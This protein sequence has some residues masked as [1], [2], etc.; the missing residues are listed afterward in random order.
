MA[1]ANELK[2]PPT[3]SQDREARECLRAWVVDGGLEVALHPQVWPQPAYWGI[4]L[5]DIV[6][7]LALAY[8]QAEGRNPEQTASEILTLLLAEFQSP[9]DQ[10]VGGFACEA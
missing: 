8:E 6:R 3:A 5:A 2:V 9:T 7:H 10:P 4:A 1:H